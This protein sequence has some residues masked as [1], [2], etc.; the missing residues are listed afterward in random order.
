MRMRASDALPIWDKLL[1]NALSTA[2]LLHKTE[3]MEVD[4]STWA[5]KLWGTDMPTNNKHSRTIQP[6]INLH[7]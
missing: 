2:S 6:I 4:D 7:V 1:F 5:Y 3:K